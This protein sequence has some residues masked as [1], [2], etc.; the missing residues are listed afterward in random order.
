MIEQDMITKNGNEVA[1]DNLIHQLQD[2]HVHIG[3]LIEQRSVDEC[4]DEI[5]LGIK[6]GHV[7]GHLNRCWNG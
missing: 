2:A 6:L 5:D 4:I 7:Y 1:W 3:S